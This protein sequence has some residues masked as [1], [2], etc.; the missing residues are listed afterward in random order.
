MKD[1]SDTFTRE[2]KLNPAPKSNAQ[3]QR[4]YRERHKDLTARIDAR[5]SI[6]SAAALNAIVKHYSMT[7]KDFI[8]KVI[9]VELEKITKENTNLS[10]SDFNSFNEKF[11]NL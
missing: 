4:D 6:D 9:A 11:W 1:D 2:L 8:E 7:K 5:I 10:D 3:S